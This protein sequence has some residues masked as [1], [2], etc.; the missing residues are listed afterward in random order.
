MLE[1]QTVADIWQGKF[2]LQ[3]GKVTKFSTTEAFQSTAYGT[4][5]GP[6]NLSYNTWASDLSINE[7][8]LSF[9]TNKDVLN[10]KLGN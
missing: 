10:Y 4:D 5:C 3:T 1:N 6:Y 7:K 8:S 9:K 2:S